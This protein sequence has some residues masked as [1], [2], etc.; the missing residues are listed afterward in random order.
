MAVPCSGA[1]IGLRRMAGV[2]TRLDR[3]GG[4]PD[5]DA[6]ADRTAIMYN[7]IRRLDEVDFT[8]IQESV[9]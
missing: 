1:D 5:G 8:L 4:T 2:D 3:P 6:G 9:W 7:R